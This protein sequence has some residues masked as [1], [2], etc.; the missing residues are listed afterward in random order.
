VIA[1]AV[2]A[3]GLLAPPAADLGVSSKS[4][5]EKAPLDFTDAVNLPTGI[6]PYFAVAVDLDRDGHLDLAASNTVSH[7][8]T[9]FL[10]QK[11]GTF[12]PSTEYPTHGYTPYA[13]A[14]GDLDGDGDPDLVCGNMFSVNYSLFFNRGDGTFEDAVTMKGEAGP[15]FTAISDLDGDGR[16]DLAL[17]NIGHDDISVYL[18]RGGRRFEH[19]E[20]YACRGVVPYS[21]AAADFSGDGRPDLV[22]GNIY[23]SN[24]SLLE[25]LGQGRFG[26]ARTFK[27]ESLTQIV[28]PPTSTATDTWTVTETG[29]PTTSPC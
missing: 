20:T 8:I 11:N 5:R 15:M 25:N 19:G 9:V 24:V 10:N 4:D 26:E 1:L 7:S 6:S 13:L 22:T 28:F 3:L 18:N 14:A 12:G 2:L 17:C 27:T 21:I 29:A 16:P 23:S